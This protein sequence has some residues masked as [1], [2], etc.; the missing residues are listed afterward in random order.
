MSCAFG[1]Q[2]FEYFSEIKRH[3]FECKLNGF[4]TLVVE[5]FNQIDDVLKKSHRWTRKTIFTMNLPDVLRRFRIFDWLIYLVRRW[6]EE[7]DPMLSCSREHISSVR[8]WHDR[9]PV[10]A[11]INRTSSRYQRG[12]AKQHVHVSWGYLCTYPSHRV[13]HQCR[14]DA[15]YFHRARKKKTVRSVVLL[16]ESVLAKG[17]PYSVHCEVSLRICPYSVFL[18][19]FVRRC[20]CQN[21][22]SNVSWTTELLQTV[23]YLQLFQF[24]LFTLQFSIQ[25][26]DDTVD[27]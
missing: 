14:S 25:I 3:L 26:I 15:W 21:S 6:I 5:T 20:L 16:H 27:C 18:R 1:Y 4:E 11:E 7:I 17:L 12:E 23:I 19:W 8:W 22:E 24:F 13:E 10:E 2:S 9:D